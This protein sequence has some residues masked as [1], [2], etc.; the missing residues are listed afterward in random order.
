MSRHPSTLTL[1]GPNDLIET[2]EEFQKKIPQ[3]FPHFLERSSRLIRKILQDMGQWTDNAAH[4]KLLLRLSFDLVERFLDYC[5]SQLPCRPSL[6]LDGFISD[7][8]GRT[9]EI[10]PEPVSNSLLYKYLDGLLNRAVMS[11]DGLICLFYHF[12]GMK[13]VEIGFFLGLEEGQTQRIYKNFARWRTKGWRMAIDHADLSTA[14]FQLL[15]DEYEHN[16]GLFNKQVHHHLESLTSFYRKSDPPYYP[17]LEGSQWHE[18]FREN[19]GL[20][21]R[22]WHLPLCLPCMTNI[23][24]LRE[25][26]LPQVDI[27]FDLHLIPHSLKDEEKPRL[28]CAKK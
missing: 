25:S 7:Y 23:N 11:R 27:S 18:M 6:I 3:N 22:M 4:E 14:E 16:P 15:I 17:C 9:V 26:F 19:Y 21:Y 2:H 8:F 24:E 20:D 12:Y 13:P 1:F 5:P 10:R 28:A